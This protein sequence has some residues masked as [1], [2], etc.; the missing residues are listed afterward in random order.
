VFTGNHYFLDGA[1]GLVA[2]A[3]GL[4]FAVFMQTR[5]YRWLRRV[6]GSR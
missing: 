4:A 1:G 3:G 6:T 2:A 5:G